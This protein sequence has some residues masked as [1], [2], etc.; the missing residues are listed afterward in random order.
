MLDGMSKPGLTA[1]VIVIA[2]PPGAGKS[3]LGALFPM[4]LFIQ[5]E[6]L[7]SV[8]DDWAEEDKPHTLP[9]LPAHDLALKKSPY[10]TIMKQ[11][12]QIGRANTAELRQQVRTLV[13]DSTSVLNA[14]LEVEIVEKDGSDS[15]GNACGGFHKAYE[16]AAGMHTKIIERA[17]RVCRKHNMALIFL[18]HTIARK[19]RNRPDA[20]EYSVWTLDMGEKAAQVYYRLSDAVLFLTVEEFVR[21]GETSKKGIT[22]KSGKI[23]S[24][25]QRIIVTCP[26]GKQGFSNAKNRMNLDAL[27]KVPADSNPLLDL[28]PFYVANPLG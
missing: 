8:F 5:A 14:L 23:I 21:G 24:T 4:P 25:G 28:I 18:G 27:I 7:S 13:I 17:K 16:V 6:E 20:E 1:P 2:G 9:I 15:M 19:M 22:T 11:L 10:D 12:D 3:T 26:E